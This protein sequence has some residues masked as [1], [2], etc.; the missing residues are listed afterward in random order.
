MRDPELTERAKQMRRE[1]T[2][3]E[4]RLWNMLRAKPVHRRLFGEGA[5]DLH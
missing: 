2:E 3:P 5:D 4:L 1:P